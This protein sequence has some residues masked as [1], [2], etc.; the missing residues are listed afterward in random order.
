MLSER[1]NVRWQHVGQ[2]GAKRPRLRLFSAA[3]DSGPSREG[4]FLR[5][6]TGRFRRSSSSGGSRRGGPFRSRRGLLTGIV[7][8]VLLIVGVVF[9]VMRGRQGPQVGEGEG[10][11]RIRSA[12]VARDSLSVT[13]SA[14][15]EVVSTSEAQLPFLVGGEVVEILV[16]A[17]DQV[18]A[19]QVLASLDSRLLELDLRDSE[20]AQ[21]LQ[22]VALEDLKA[23]ATEE[24][25]QLA[26]A[27]ASLAQAQL[28]QATAPPT[29]YDLQIAELGVQQARNEL[30][31][32]QSNRDVIEK[33]RRPPKDEPDFEVDKA[34]DTIAAAEFGV[35][36]AQVQFENLLQGPRAGQVATARAQVVAAQAALDNLLEGPS[37]FDLAI[38]QRQI[39]LAGLSV[40]LARE[41]LDDAT[42]RAPYSGTV[43]EVDV[44][45]GETVGAGTAVITIIDEKTLRLELDVDEV[46]IARV[47]PEQP[48]EITFDALPGEVA[49]GVVERVSP[50][51]TEVAGVVTYN[52]RVALDPQSEPLPI[53]AGMTATA[54]ITV[55]E[56]TNALL[57]PNWA[58]RIDR[59]TGEAF[60][61][62]RSPDG[63]IEE[64]SVEIGLRNN[65]FSEVLSGL[66]SGDEVVV[67]EGDEGFSFFG[68]GEE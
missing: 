55:D 60:V 11:D 12:N 31:R 3:G 67:T 59:R 62:V 39:E 44:V 13:V 24:E 25:L 8:A 17:G 58:V 47:R 68:G 1:L 27:N 42:I 61:S 19:G 63:I 46:D 52:T 32:T 38:A 35:E 41:A 50:V 51:S 37:E 43:S 57:V 64:V 21:E 53:R 18:E 2:M 26:R 48:V 23:G 20:I 65:A 33:A 14:T 34:E 40:D 9:L 54:V 49:T 5:G 29:I 66:D 15:G 36:A 45:E 7:V 10:E 28:N 6:I 30:F 4:G 56:L 16:E 22:V